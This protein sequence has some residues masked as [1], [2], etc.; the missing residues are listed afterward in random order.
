VAEEITKILITDDDADVRELLMEA[1]RSWGYQ[2]AVAKDGEEALVRL[3]ME[4]VNIVITDLMMP[5]MDGMDLLQRIHELDAEIQVVMITGYATI[6]TALKAM[7]SGAYDY[8]AKPF[9]LDELMIVI[10]KACEWRRIFSQNKEL[11]REL[12][13]AY[14]E[15][16]QLKAN[17]AES[18]VTS[19]G[20]PGAIRDSLNGAGLPLRES[21]DIYKQQEYIREADRLIR[22]R[23]ALKV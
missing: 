14:A 17:L 13:A 15:I 21:A 12:R 6:E 19:T 23:F 3:R 8:I 5:R 9:R 20:A 18:P 22:H 10:R 1:V 16:I 7:Q 4:K 2:A 11:L